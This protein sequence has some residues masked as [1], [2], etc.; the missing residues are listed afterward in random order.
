MASDLPKLSD[1]RVFRADVDAE[2]GMRTILAAIDALDA[3]LALHK[4]FSWIENVPVFDQFDAPTRM[5]HGCT[6][7]GPSYPCQTVSAIGT[8]IDV[9]G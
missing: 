8:H 1:I 6:C 5:V 3:V 2:I 7:T 4:P 9:E